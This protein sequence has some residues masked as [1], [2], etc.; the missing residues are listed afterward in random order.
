VGV[1]LAALATAAT[2]VALG[3]A[4]EDGPEAALAQ[5]RPPVVILV[6][7]EFPVD[8]LLRPDGGIDAERFPNFASLARTSTWFPN[9]YSIYDST[10][11]IVP[12]IMDSIRPRPATVPDQRDHPRSLYQLFHRLG[13][14]VVDV[15]PSTAVCPPRVCAR[16]RRR[17]PRVL[18]RLAGPGRPSRFTRWIRSMRPSRRPILYVQHALLPHEPWIYLPSGKRSRPEGEDPVPGLNRPGGFHDREL[19]HHNEARYL[20]QVGF[21]DRLIGRLLRRLRDTG[22]EEQALVV[23]TADHGYS[24][25]IGVNDRRRV[26]R[27]NVDEIAPVPLFV[28]APGQRRAV[29]D[30]AYVSSIDVLPTIADM[31]DVRLGW[32]HDGRSAYSPAVRRRR[33]VRLATRDFREV[34]SIGGLSLLRQRAAN[35]RRRAGLFTTGAYSEV[36][37]GSPWASLFRIGPNRRLLGRPLSGLRPR[38][39][40]PTVARVHNARLLS[41]A[42]RTSRILPIKLSGVIEGTPGRDLR[43]LAISVNGR[44]QAVGRSFRLRG[45]PGESFSILIPDTSLRPGH[46]QVRVFEV[47]RGGRSPELT[48]LGEV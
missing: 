22:L 3:R 42:S 26:T 5:G 18:A 13:Y 44:I 2:V 27:R 48:L 31:L 11:K 43:E 12:A 14:G 28:K 39:G 32:R 30:S 40:G 41:S 19:T 46:N 16:A 35:R 24:F 38:R 17:R 34:I 6:L 29:V 9:A 25:E 47:V 1:L 33:E 36:L 15:E 23:V 37:F 8:S 10:F 7:D 4:R 20:L 21:V 45:I